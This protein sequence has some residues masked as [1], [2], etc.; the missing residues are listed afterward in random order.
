[1][2]FRLALANGDDAQGAQ[3]AKGMQGMQ[4]AGND[5]HGRGSTRSPEDAE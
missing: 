1:M 3:G 4:R 2:R 5:D